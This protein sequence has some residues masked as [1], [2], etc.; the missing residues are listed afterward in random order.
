MKFKCYTEYENELNPL[1]IGILHSINIYT[2]FTKKDDNKKI[3]KYIRDNWGKLYFDSLKNLIRCNKM[4]KEY[5]NKDINNILKKSCQHMKH[6]FLILCNNIKKYEMN[7]KI[8]I[9]LVIKEWCGFLK[10]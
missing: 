1:S 4:P 6:D 8:F 5:V 10:D 3:S 9:D 7:E 2:N